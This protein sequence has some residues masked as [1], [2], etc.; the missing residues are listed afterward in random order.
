MM[1]AVQFDFLDASHG[2]AFLSG[3]TAKGR[4]DSD[5]FWTADGG[6][7]WS[8][9]RPTGTGSVGNEGSV[10]FATASEGVIV[11]A[12]HGTGVVATHD[13]GTTW[14]DATLA[15]PSGTAGAQLYMGQPRFF[16]GRS[17]LLAVD[18]QSDTGSVVHVYRTS[19]AGASWTVQSTLPQGFFDIA[20]LGG[21][22]W[23]SAGGP[24]ILTSADG[25]L[26][27]VR[28]PA[29][30]LPGATSPIMA[31]ADHGWALVYMGVCLSFKSDCQ[32]RT[33]LYSTADGGRSW[34]QLEP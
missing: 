25:G 18:F 1:P 21:Q 6:A 24:E 16:D 22:R 12:L 20:F 11:N 7:T 19:D 3:N 29:T 28:G 32:S 10:A 4:N 31:D 9:D 2:F 27:W 13:G 26:T 17:G 23:L 14:T 15:L 33:G 34:A 30:G 8:V 5:L